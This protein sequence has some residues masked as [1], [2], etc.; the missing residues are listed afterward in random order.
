MYN[1]MIINFIMHVYNIII[2]IVPYNV[3]YKYNYR[4]VDYVIISRPG[5]GSTESCGTD[6]G[7]DNTNQFLF[8]ESNNIFMVIVI[9]NF[10]YSA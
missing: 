8:R 4:C 10:F 1:I 6:P 7:S 2:I 3:I 5:Y 9:I